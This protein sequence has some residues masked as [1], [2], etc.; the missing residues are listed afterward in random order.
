MY[1]Q[2]SGQKLIGSKIMKRVI[3]MILAVSMT[4]FRMRRMLL[5]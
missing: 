1:V 2:L 5:K 4:L 3:S